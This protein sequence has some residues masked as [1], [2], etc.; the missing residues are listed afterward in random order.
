M[1]LSI[2]S[3][4]LA[5]DITRALPIIQSWGLDAVDLRGRIFGKGIHALDDAELKRLRALLDDHGMSVGCLE[6]SLA[7]AHWP[8]PARRQEEAV[9]LEG[10]IRAA[11]ALDCRLVRSFVFW[12]P[13]RPEQGR[14][15]VQPDV[16]QKTVDL[17]AP[18]AERA[19]Q[20][21]LT[22]AFENCGVMPEEVFAIL[23]TLDVP[24]W[25]MA[26]DVA[27]TWDCAERRRDE[28]GY[29]QRMLQRALVVHVKA[30]GAL[31]GLGRDLI[32]YGKVLKACHDAGLRGPV[33]AETH[34]PDKSVSDE[35]Q[36]HRLVEAIKSAWPPAA[37]TMKGR[38]LRSIQ[39][40]WHDK[41]VGFAVVG[42]GM[43]HENCKKVVAA[44]GC[45]L[46][47]VA[48]LRAQRAERTGK[49]FGVPWTT[50]YRTLLDRQDVEVVYVVTETGNHAAV[51]LDA[52]AAG[53]HVLVTKPMEANV[54]ACDRM[55]RAAEE[56]RVLLAVDFDRQYR[57]EMVTLRE[58]VARGVFGRLLSG[59]CSMKI[60]RTM[61]YFQENGGWRG[62]FQLDGGGVM[63]NQFIHHIADLIFALG[64]PAKVCANVW[65]QAHAIEAEDL[66]TAT[67]W[68]ENGLVV[69]LLA[70]TS[71]PQPTW[72]L[73]MELTGADGAY[74]HTSGGPHEKPQTRWYLN[75][76]WS[77]QP[78][79][80][81][82]S[83]W[84]NAADNMAAAIRSGAALV[85][86]G[87]AGRQSRAVLDAMYESALRRN[88]DWVT[89]VP[90]GAGQ[91][92]GTR[93]QT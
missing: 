61:S 70:T 40:A 49:E 13:P 23:D 32:P 5:T 93:I 31:A 58:A 89:P 33:S 73:R 36:S 78:P 3:D 45:R 53:K 17:F 2:F 9:K 60:L 84:L 26:W 52:M 85:C 82:E 46:V 64:M 18:L 87:R 21:G 86:D 68:Y 28:D 62:T 59:E 56:H 41:P 4:E 12:Q 72:Y 65:T 10:L 29:I 77:E 57:S 66:G 15:A 7:K 37:R 20:A 71:Y 27:N 43:G 44:S 55:I 22:L 11:D 35:E 79:V 16:L 47:G 50:D 54:E 8:E 63:S 19:R 25:G 42:L 81:V 39:R 48:D 88:G 92:H 80:T 91:Q 67:W 69:S 1:Y 24:G 75:K 90:F 38:P 6:S 30:G 74:A 83:P 76:K 51:A 14:L 34:N